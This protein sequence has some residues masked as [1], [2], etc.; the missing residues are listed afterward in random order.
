MELSLINIEYYIWHLLKLN[1]SKDIFLEV[2]NFTLTFLGACFSCLILKNFVKS[3][4]L[5][6]LFWFFYKIETS[7]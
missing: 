3:L 6:P 7:I 4:I 2:K 5:S 1:K